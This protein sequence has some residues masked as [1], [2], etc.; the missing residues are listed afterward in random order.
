MSS[1]LLPSNNGPTDEFSGISEGNERRFVP[2]H[3]IARR[4]K[5]RSA[6]PFFTGRRRGSVLEISLELSDAKAFGNWF[7]RGS[8]NVTVW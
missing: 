5:E 8:S 3:Q 4:G 7:P 2:K 1:C 6:G